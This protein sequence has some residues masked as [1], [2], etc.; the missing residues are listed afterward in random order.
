ELDL[1]EIRAR[2]RV[3]QTVT[4]ECAG[5]GRARLFP[6]PISQPW[7]QEA[8]GTSSWTGTPLRGLLREAG[9][10][11]GTVELVFTGCDDGVEKGYEHDYARSLTVDEANREEVLLAYEM[12]GRALEPQHGFPLRL[13]IPGWY[14]MAHVKWLQRIEAVRTPFTGYQ[15]TVAYQYKTDAN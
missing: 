7:L 11:P 12:N 4:L 8:V 2:P 5:N 13:L 6:R 10:K 3:T 15:Q 9:L 14:G 1:E